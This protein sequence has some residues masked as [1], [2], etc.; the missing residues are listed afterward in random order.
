MFNGSDANM[1][2]EG[3]CGQSELDLLSVIRCNFQ[4]LCHLSTT[5]IEE[6]R[7]GIGIDVDACV[8]PFRR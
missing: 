6:K 4:D 2:T 8:E 3:L 5:T 1:A 7:H